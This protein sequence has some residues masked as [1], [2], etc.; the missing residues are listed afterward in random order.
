MKKI[1][2]TVIALAVMICAVP[3]FTSCEKFLNQAPNAE[4][5]MDYIFQDYLRSVRYLDLLYYYMPANWTGEGKFGEDYYGMLESATDMSDYSATYGATNRAFNSGNWRAGSAAAEVSIWNSIYQQIRRAYMVLENIDS[6]NNEPE[7]RK[8]TMRGECYFM[9]GYYYF[10]LMKRYG[11]VPL[12]KEVLTLESDLK[13]PRASIQ[14]MEDFICQN[15]DMAADLL[16]YRWDDDNLGRADKVWAMSIK[17]RLL[18]YTASPLSNPDGNVEKWKNAANAAKEVIDYCNASNQYYLSHDWENIF[19][20]NFADRISEIIIYKVVSENNV[21]F[22]S[23]LVRYGHA[24]PGDG[25]WGYASNNPSQ[26]FV[27]R[28]EVIKFDSDGKA[29]GSETF[30]WN[31]P[32]HVENIYKN[33]DP[34]F[35]YTVLYN[36]RYW[37]KRAIGTWRDG[38]TYGPDIDPKNHLYSKTGYYL[39]KFWPR[40]CPDKNNP[41]GAKVAGFYLR[42]SEIY[43]NYAEAMNEAYGPDATLNDSNPLTAIEAVNKLRERLVCPANSSIGGESDP[44]YYIKV[45]RTENPDFPV[46]PNGMPLIP[47]GLSKDAARAKIHNERTIEL[48]FEDQYFYDILR[49]KRG[50]EL[51]NG[52]LYGV[53]AIKSG[54]NFTYS[55]K[56]V[57]DRYFDSK[58]MYYYPI[59]QSEVYSLGIEQNPGW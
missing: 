20:R 50:D 8:E 29:V 43:L 17:S 9:I 4:E 27:D 19:I 42:L 51:I 32:S 35:Y 38:T 36:N 47:T 55:K 14:E 10:E 12:V 3:L 39:R 24:S 59:P 23:K 33:R 41:G 30:N 5:S 58:R 25:F 22:N 15:L 26:N 31:N 56:K 6:F 57:E 13:I 21:T 2:Y 18:L 46:L 40:E 54:A 49:W 11:G 28:F 52:T 1:K 7:G 16:P 34:R 44:Y 45:E 37:I 48:S 53:D